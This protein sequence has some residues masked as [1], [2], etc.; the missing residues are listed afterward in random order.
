LATNQQKKINTINSLQTSLHDRDETSQVVSRQ[1]SE[2][3]QADKTPA[4]PQ[5]TANGHGR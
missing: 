2:L 3:I 1:Q 4:V 5:R